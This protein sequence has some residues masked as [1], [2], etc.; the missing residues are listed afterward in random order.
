M[1]KRRIRTLIAV[2]ALLGLMAG[3]LWTATAQEPEPPPAAW[4]HGAVQAGG[5]GSSSLGEFKAG[6]VLLRLKEGVSISAVESTLDRYDATRVR[7][8]YHSNVELWRVPEGS[9]LALVEQLN[10]DPSV[11]FAEPNYLY[12]AFGTPNDPEFS[13]QWAHTLMQ[14]PAVWDITTGSTSITIAIIDTGIDEGHPDLA[15][16]I[17][18]GYDFVDGDADPHDLNGHG[19]HVAG[20]AAA[21]TDNGIGVAGMDWQARIMPVR[22]LDDEGSGYGSHITEGIRWAYEN[23]ARVLNLSLGGS[24]SSQAMQ[25]AVNDAHAAGSLVV[26]AM[27]NCRTYDPPACPVANPT[28]YPAACDNV[29]AVAAT[30]PAD[31]YA[32]Y[33][34]YGLHCDI[35]APGGDMGYY[36]DPDGIYSTMPT[37][38]VYLTTHYSYYED[39]DY[40]NGT[41][42]A[43]PYVAGLATLVWSVNSALTPDQVQD[44]IE[45]TADDLGAPGWDQDYGHGRVNALAA[46]QSVAVPGAPELLPISNPDGDGDY[47][48]DWSD[49]PDAISYTL[50]E[51]DDLAFTSPVVRYSGAASEFQV[52]GQG[53]GI[54][55]YRVRAS[56]DAGDGPWSNTR[57]TGVVPDAPV[58]SPISKAPSEDEYVVDWSDVS[59]AAGYRLQEDDDVSFTSPI[60]RYVGMASQYNVTGQRGGTWYYQVRAYNAAGESPWSTPPQSATVPPPALQPPLLYAI[61]NA[62]GDDQYL[63]DWTEV[64]SA[65]TYT[66]EESGD[67]YFGDPTVVYTGTVSQFTVADQQVGTWYYR[68]RA[69]GPPPDRSPWS[70]QR[71]AAVKAWAYLNLVAVN[72]SSG[73]SFGL[74]INE[75]FEGGVVPPSGWTMVQTNPRQTWKVTT[76]RPYTGSY[77][78]DCEYDDQLEDQDEML[79]SPVFRA[80][81]AQ[82]QFYSFGSPYWCRDTYDNCDLKVWLVVGGWGDGG[83]IH[84]HTAD[85][86]WIGT[87]EWSLSTVDLTPYLGSLPVGALVRVGFQYE[88]NDGA[89]VALDAIS[90]TEQ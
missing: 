10:A 79:L 89:Q 39:Y 2:L 46:V 86:D 5:S 61:D 21:V 43:T 52:T 74:P 48:V 36:H 63:V 35:A 90:I 78:A 12:H 67:P 8:L 42:Q 59:G 40:L 32:P 23:G 66:L 82:L 57:S 16:K 77:R 84:V 41:S 54:W 9:E 60:T 81:N 44:A 7:S 28:S 56:N 85:D 55:Y 58:L 87:W 13:R 83:D 25:D 50:Q 6:E 45:G 3:G 47:L 14:S 27:G 22:V 33:S 17:V 65:T 26:A 53:G 80:S 62:D 18:A 88:G 51:D 1:T 70:G 73:G 64:P 71:S 37:Y 20:I 30:G 38:P 4:S 68:V 76:T 31:A 72:H 49:V 19:T 24:N 15:S 29:V 69:F 75:G 11:E 34:Q